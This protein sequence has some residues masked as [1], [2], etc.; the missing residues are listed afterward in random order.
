MQVETGDRGADN[1]PT[2]LGATDRASHGLQK[3]QYDND[4]DALTVYTSPSEIVGLRWRIDANMIQVDHCFIKDV[5]EER[6]RGIIWMDKVHTHF[7]KFSH[8]FP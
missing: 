7:D 4:S 8:K 1:T 3:R 2:R 5:S 6:D